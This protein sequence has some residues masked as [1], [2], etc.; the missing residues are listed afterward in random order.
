MAHSTLRLKIKTA[1]K[2]LPVPTP[3]AKRAVV[4]KLEEAYQAASEYAQTYGPHHHF[5][6][7]VTGQL[8]TLRVF[9]E[10][11]DSLGFPY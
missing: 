8:Y 10:L 5:G 11:L 4:Q 9:A 3:E 7:E 2:A 1:R 6:A